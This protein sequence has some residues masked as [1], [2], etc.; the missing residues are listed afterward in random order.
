MEVHLNPDLE[1]SSTTLR[2]FQA[3]PR[4]TW[5]KTQS[6]GILENWLICAACSMAAM[7]I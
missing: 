5:R 4:T 6:P 3:V 7:T 2:R 1:N